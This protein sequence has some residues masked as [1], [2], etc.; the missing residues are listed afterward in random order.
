MKILSLNAWHATQRA[1]LETLIRQQYDTTD[2]FCFQ[3][4]DGDAIES[5]LGEI[6]ADD[7]FTKEVSIKTSSSDN[8]VLTSYVRNDMTVVRKV[9]LLGQTGD[10]AGFIQVLHLQ[11]DDVLFAIANVHGAPRPGD[12]LDT[13]GRIAQSQALIDELATCDGV[14]IAIGDFNLL[15]DV[16]SVSMIEA[17]GYDNLITRYSIPTT[18][19]ELA[20]DRFPHNKQLFADY[21]FVA[22]V[23]RVVSFTVPRVFASD[24]LPMLLDID[25][26]NKGAL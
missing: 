7:T 26:I 11:R 5:L 24:H 12:K 18:R 2:I 6:F 17:A 1:E 9:E 19:N 13:P 3:E 21:A 20:W 15:P 22:G 8:D 16:Q 10:D 23:S 14:R 4:S 25:L